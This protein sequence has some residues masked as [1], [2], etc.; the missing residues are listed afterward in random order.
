MYVATTPFFP[1]IYFVRNNSPDMT[2]WNFEIRSKQKKRVKN[3]F[4]RREASLFYYYL[5]FSRS[6]VLNVTSEHNLS[7]IILKCPV[8]KQTELLE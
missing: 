7:Y 4:K 1:I 2:L 6:P 3:T 5:F 8:S